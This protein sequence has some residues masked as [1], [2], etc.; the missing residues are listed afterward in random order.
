M[1]QKIDDLGLR[2]VVP[3]YGIRFG[4]FDPAQIQEITG[5]TGGK[6][7]DASVDL[8]KAYREAKGYS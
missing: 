2:D 1:S 6:Y 7:F 5:F 4:S 3:V 8:V